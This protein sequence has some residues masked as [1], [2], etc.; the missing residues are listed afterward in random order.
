MAG[1]SAVFGIGRFGDERRA[2]AGALILERVVET[3]SLVVRRIGGD[4]AGEMMVHRFLSSPAVQVDE[5]VE[6]VSART[7]SACAGRVVV[8][9]QDTTEINFAGRERARVGLGP[10]GDGKSAGFF[11]HPVL[12]VDAADEA[13]LGV[14]DLQIWSRSGTPAAPRRQRELADKESVRWLKAAAA[15]RLAGAARVVTVGDRENDIYGFFARR[16]AGVDLVV[17]AAQDRALVDGDRLF[18]A[19]ADWPELA[20]TQVKVAPRGPGDRGRIAE[21]ALRAGPVQ[22]RRPRNGHDPADPPALALNLVEVREV[23]DGGAGKPL[24]WRL[25][26]TLPVDDVAAAEQVVQ[27][28]RLRWR[29]EQCF[30]ALKSDGLALEDVQLHERERLFKLAGIALVAAARTIQLVD[31]RDGSSRPASD[32]IDPALIEAAEAIGRSKEGRTPRQQNPHPKGSLAWLAWIIARL[33]GW[34]CYY[35]PPGPKTMRTGWNQFAAM[36]AGY[37]MAK[38]PDVP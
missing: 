3:G 20:R 18:A 22:V 13:L 10:A 12:A 27:F 15:A 25:I 30:R 29:I 33:G 17:R 36:A 38:L 16:P 31:A 35:K 23:G 4:R 19:A 9:V 32:V 1:R 34:N 11:M 24:L 28:Y 37:V 6:T 8:A 2:Q 21:V 5:I 26:T 7:A 14:V